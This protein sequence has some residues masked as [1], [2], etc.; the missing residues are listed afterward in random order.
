M[1]FF[2][3]TALIKNVFSFYLIDININNENDDDKQSFEKKYVN[4]FKDS[5]YSFQSSSD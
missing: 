3:S 4:K 5:D 1:K 2:E